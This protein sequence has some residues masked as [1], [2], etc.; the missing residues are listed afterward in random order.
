MQGPI[1]KS[2][3][4]LDG[5][6]DIPRKKKRKVTADQAADPE[7]APPKRLKPA[8]MT[9]Q[10]AKRPAP[11]KSLVQDLDKVI[12]ACWVFGVKLPLLHAVRPQL[13]TKQSQL[14]SLEQMG[15]DRRSAICSAWQWHV[16]IITCQ[17]V[18]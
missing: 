14:S 1:E 17:L 6:S 9:P 5:V 11:G 10:G 18:D 13:P 12:M 3:T 4:R 7:A 8:K 15:L 16:T 2:D